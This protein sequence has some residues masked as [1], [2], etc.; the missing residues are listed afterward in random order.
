MEGVAADESE[1]FL[2]EID[3]LRES[4]AVGRIVGFI[5]LT[6]S[7]RTWPLNETQ[8]Y[9]AGAGA[10]EEMVPGA[11]VSVQGDLVSEPAGLAT[12]R[13]SVY[14]AHMGCSMWFGAE[15]ADADS[16]IITVGGHTATYS[17]SQLS[18]T[19]WTVELWSSADVLE[20]FCE[21]DFNAET[22]SRSMVL[23]LSP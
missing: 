3:A 2:A 6:E 20:S 4:A 5:H 23:E 13:G 22:C 7:D 16:Y 15:V 11:L 14:D 8:P 17:A 1:I 12:L 9:C 10:F 19:G 18:A 21:E